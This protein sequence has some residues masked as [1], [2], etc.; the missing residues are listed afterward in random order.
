MSAPAGGRV[1]VPQ[2]TGKQ[3]ATRPAGRVVT[4]QKERQNGH[5]LGRCRRVV[6]WSTL[7]QSPQS[8]ETEP[9]VRITVGGSVVGGGSGKRRV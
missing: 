9:N 5:G 1:I 8:G 4:F 2:T 6:T 3:S 7:R